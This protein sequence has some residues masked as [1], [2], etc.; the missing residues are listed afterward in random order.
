MCGLG[1]GI[2]IAAFSPKSCRE[3]TLKYSSIQ[4]S[5]VRS[6]V[7]AK[8]VYQ[9]HSA[10]KFRPQQFSPTQKTDTER[11]LRVEALEKVGKGASHP[12]T[13]P[14][15]HPSI[16]PSM[17]TTVPFRTLARSLRFPS[18]PFPPPFPFP[19][20]LSFSLPPFDSFFFFHPPS[21]STS[22]SSS[23]APFF[24]VSPISRFFSHFPLFSS[25]L[26]IQFSL[27]SHP[28]IFFY[29]FNPLS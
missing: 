17:P 18:F 12:S 16:H 7:K 19:F 4:H 11:E 8:K 6:L 27:P 22:H 24:G 3:S 25:L 2:G 28:F 21:T 5:A 20:P 13:H 9:Q 15:I 14:P 29:F 23:S 26:L 10:S 1:V